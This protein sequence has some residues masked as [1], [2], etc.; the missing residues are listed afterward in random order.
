MPEK[1]L[2]FALQGEKIAWINQDYTRLFS[3]WIL[4]GSIYVRKKKMSLAEEYLL[5]GL[6]LQSKIKQT[7]FLLFGLKNYTILLIMKEDWKIANEIIESY[8]KLGESHE[9]KRSII[10]ALLS[11]GSTYQKQM[12]FQEAIKLYEIAEEIA[13]GKEWNSLL[14]DIV[15][16]L[17]YCYKL[18]GEQSKFQE[19]I[20]KMY[21]LQLVKEKKESSFFVDSLSINL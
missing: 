6:N 9:D 2:E 13:K 15:K 3:L 5:K 19:Y 21:H 16:E 11:I 12:Q 1:A 14:L 4:I 8:L 17:W 18:I 20:E 10:E 7:D